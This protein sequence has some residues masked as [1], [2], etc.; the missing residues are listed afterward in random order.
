MINGK[1][2]I[3][4]TK[5]ECVSILYYSFWM[6]KSNLCVHCVSCVEKFLIENH[7]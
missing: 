1:V 5:L 7:F 3:G 4:K 6:G 2:L